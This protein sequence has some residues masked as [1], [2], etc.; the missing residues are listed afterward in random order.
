MLHLL[1]APAALLLATPVADYRASPFLSGTQLLEACQS[2]RPGQQ[3]LCRGYVA[4]AEDYLEFARNLHGEGRCVPIGTPIDALE[5]I[6]VA[7]LEARR[8]SDH[9]PAP[10]LL[11]YAYS[12]AWHCE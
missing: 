6:A 8:P 3:A 1:L 12:A 11:F 9:L 4:G 5:N 2:P 7:H 10:V